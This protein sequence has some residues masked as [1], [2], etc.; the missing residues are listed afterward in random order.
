MPEQV[1]VPQPS[2]NPAPAAEPKAVSPTEIIQRIAKAEQVQP[3]P[4]PEEP[5]KVSLD[6]IKDPAARAVA[7]KKIR[8]LEAG[9]NRKFMSLAEEKKQV[10]ALRQQLERDTNQ[11]WT[12]QRLQEM[13]Q[14]PDF[15]Q[16]VQTAYQA[17]AHATPPG[18][19]EGSPEQWSNLS[20]SDKQAFR[21]L[22]GKL[23]TVLSNQEQAQ[24]AQEHERVKTRFPDYNPKVVEDFYRDANAGKVSSERIKE[25]I[26]KAMNFDKYVEN[27]YRFGQEDRQGNLQ[28]KINGSTSPSN[29]V[30]RTTADMPTRN[31]GESTSSF[32]SRLARWNFTRIKKGS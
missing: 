9:F 30:V 23:N 13:L 28:E 18:N 1:V 19:W 31:D 25:M 10:E 15:A 4:A 29:N 32:M 8:D 21:Q 2:A 26:W 3:T 5:Q 20:D 24:H 7:E 6:D 14:R 17:Q 12:P 27:S 22:E 11:V 16:A